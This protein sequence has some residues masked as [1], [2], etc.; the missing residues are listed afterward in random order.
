L[1]ATVPVPTLVDALQQ[2]QQR[3]ATLGST[4][5]ADDPSA[6]I[7]AL[8]EIIHGLIAHRQTLSA[9][10]D[11]SQPVTKPMPE[12]ATPPVQ[13][14]ATVVP[15][16]PLQR[17]LIQDGLHSV[18]LAQQWLQAKPEMDA[19]TPL[20]MAFSTASDACH[21][22]ELGPLSELA[23][24]IATSFALL[25]T[26]PPDHVSSLDQSALQT[27]IN[28]FAQALKQLEAGSLVTPDPA[29]LTA[30]I[31]FQQQ[32][33]QQAP[34]PWDE[35]TAA[36]PV[37]PAPTN[38][39]EV[40]PPWQEDTPASPPSAPVQRINSV[41][42]QQVV[43][44]PAQWVETYVQ[45][46]QTGRKER[47]Q[48]QSQLS[49]LDYQLEQLEADGSALLAEFSS[50]SGY[51][52]VSKTLMAS[53]RSGLSLSQSLQ[54]SSQQTQAALQQQQQFQQRLE[55][56]I[57]GWQSV[58]LGRLDYPLQQHLQHLEAKLGRRID[59]QLEEA[60]QPLDHSQLSAWQEPLKLLMTQ[61]A[62]HG[63][64][65]SSTRAE[66]GKPDALQLRLSLFHSAHETGLTLSDDGQGIPLAPLMAR[67]RD[68][69]VPA[70]AL[71]S[72]PTK[73][74]ALLFHPKVADTLAQ[75]PLPG[76]GAELISAAQ[77]ITA[78]G[79]S[80]TLHSQVGVG[81][82]YTLIFPRTA[83]LAKP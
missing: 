81:T 6:I 67:A 57:E 29:L 58:P 82:R 40:T 13:P 1:L 59:L 41:R 44:L 27:A 78:L 54:L 37:D 39:Q 68:Q 3:L 52:A 2:L 33:E 79:G 73:L 4:A 25:Q 60:E 70:Q 19:L 20:V 38:G 22:L 64:D 45:L 71:Q 15:T 46:A 12:A 63:F 66:L 61:A 83:A 21:A 72:T 24:A 28:S 9:Q 75:Q 56:H 14:A 26:L 5:T 23:N 80:L 69:A 35:P 47:E 53:L 43:R 10:E 11:A 7:Q 36:E 49:D 16:N 76:A 51:G 31:E 42:P 8:H 34:P 65:A 50:H 55:D 62:Q 74:L 48:M 77:L 18:T 30:L 32:A 17:V